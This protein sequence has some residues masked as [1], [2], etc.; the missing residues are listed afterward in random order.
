MSQSYSSNRSLL[1]F[2]AIILKVSSYFLYAPNKSS[3]MSKFFLYKKAHLSAMQDTEE[4][5][6]PPNAHTI[7]IV[8]CLGGST[9]AFP[10][11][12]SILISK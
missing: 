3:T 2:M 5:R 11:P 6:S 9:S 4:M 12:T 8:F 10:T 1:T 7:H